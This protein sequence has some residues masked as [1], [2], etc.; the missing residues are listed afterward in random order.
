[1]SAKDLTDSSWTKH[2]LAML[3]GLVSAIDDAK[4]DPIRV[5]EC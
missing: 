4:V 2:E 5:R 3:L 1:M